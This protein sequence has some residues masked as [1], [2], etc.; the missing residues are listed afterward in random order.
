M[1]NPSTADHQVDDH[2]IRRVTHFTRSWGHD[3]LTVVNLYPFRSP[4]PAECRRWAEGTDGVHTILQENVALVAHYTKSA[5][6]VVAAWGNKAWDEGWIE[7]VVA[8]ILEGEGPGQDIYCLGTTKWDA[9]IHPGARG[10]HRV[11]DDQQPVLW[12]SAR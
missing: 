1:L 12:R 5:A 11:P 4:D 8:A 10:K 9:P 6:L 2:T 7:S 3:G